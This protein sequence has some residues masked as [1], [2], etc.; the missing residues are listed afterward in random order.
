MEQIEQPKTIKELKARILRKKI[1]RYWRSICPIFFVIIIWAFSATSGES[2]QAS[3]SAFANM[4]GI[5]NALAR[6]L[7]HFILFAGLG[8]SISSFLKGLNVSQFP[9]LTTTIYTTVFAVAYAAI[10]EVHQLAIA[11]RNGSVTDVLI[12]S[13]AGFAG[14]LAYIA[15][16]CYVR[17]YRFK[18]ALQN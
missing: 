14:V 8:Y 17:R 11:G 3:S 15:I 4:F 12:D 5:S 2:S 13:L 1:E 9:T 18:Q 10:D 7:A 16:F 6:K